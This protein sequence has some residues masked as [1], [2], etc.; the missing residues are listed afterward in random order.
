M[1]PLRR[2]FLYTLILLPLAFGLWYAAGALF[3]APAAWLAGQLA[4]L[5]LPEWIV[6]ST[7]ESTTWVIGSGWGQLDG[8]VV[9][10]SSAGNQLVFEV[11]TRLVS[12]GVAFYAALVA[13]SADGEGLLRFFVGLAVLWVFMAI[14]LLAILGKD[15]LINI[16]DAFLALPGVPPAEV[17]ALVYQFSVLLAPTLLPVAIWA[18]QLRGS[19]LWESLAEGVRAAASR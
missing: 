9:N 17:I 10:A 4:G 7:L 18:F 14:G 16:G 6:E 8:Q 12:Y 3:A 5:W 11:N 15:L 19:P 2:Q 1:N 13:A